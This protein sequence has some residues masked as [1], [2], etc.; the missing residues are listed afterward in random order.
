[1]LHE[2][3]LCGLNAQKQV[4]INN[5]YKGVCVGGYYADIIVENKIILE[6]KSC[7]NISP[8]HK[9]Q[10]LN[11]LTATKIKVGYILNFWHDRALEYTRL[12]K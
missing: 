6:L 7:S 10:L 9:A 5:Q 12:V 8:T 1:M 3:S 11:Y 2:L 4:P